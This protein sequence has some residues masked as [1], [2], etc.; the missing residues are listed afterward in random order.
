MLKEF[1]KKIGTTYTTLDT[2][3]AYETLILASIVERE[4]RDDAN[5]AIVAGILSKRIKE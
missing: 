2:K 4:E 1:S 3:K 5:Q